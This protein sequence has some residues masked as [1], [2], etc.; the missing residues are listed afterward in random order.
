M[1]KNCFKSTE[2]RPAADT[3]PRTL[4]FEIIMIYNKMFVPVAAII[5]SSCRAPQFAANE[6]RTQASVE[7]TNERSD[8][9]FRGGE[10]E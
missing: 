9:V 1:S 8:Q 6:A 7:N 3:D 2:G 4:T 5:Q 10:T